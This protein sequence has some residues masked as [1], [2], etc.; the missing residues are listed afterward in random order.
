MLEKDIKNED[1]EK[2]I[3]YSEL[4]DFYGPLISDSQR[5]VYDLYILEDYGITEI[6]QA[7]GLS[8][9]AVFERIKRVN[10]LLEDYEHK[11]GLKCRFEK[12]SGIFDQIREKVDDLDCDKNSHEWKELL[13]LL[14]NADEEV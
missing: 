1:I 4:Y 9:Q 14:K 3:Y 7:L 10:I 11:L 5:Q 13:K 2:R 6:G 12:L 8:R